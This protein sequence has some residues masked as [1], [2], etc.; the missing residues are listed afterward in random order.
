[1]GIF[2]KGT[3]ER[4]LR[5][6][7]L[8]L[9]K[10]INVCR[11]SETS[12]NLSKEMQEVVQLN[13]VKKIDRKPSK[14]ADSGSGNS[15]SSGNRESCSKGKLG[16]DE[17]SG[18]KRRVHHVEE[19]EQT[20]SEGEEFYVSS[21]GRHVGAVH[22]GSNR[23]WTEELQVNERKIKFKL[24]TGAESKQTLN[25]FLKINL[26]LR[27]WALSSVKALHVV[28]YGDKG[29]PR[30]T[31]KNLRNF[32]NFPWDKESEEYSTKTDDVKNKLSMPDLVAVC[33]VLDLNYAGSEDEVIERISSFLNDFNFEDENDDEDKDAR[34]DDG[35]KTFITRK[36]VIDDY[37]A[38]SVKTETHKKTWKNEEVRRDER[39]APQSRNKKEEKC[40]N[41]GIQGHRSTDCP[42]K[43]KGV[44]CFRCHQFGH[45]SSRCNDKEEELSTSGHVNIINLGYKNSV[46]L[47]V[48]QL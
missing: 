30:Q 24:D 29:L 12:K 43:A 46:T 15:N 21:L 10:T 13:V 39:R 37:D 26:N 17:A 18:S 19:H 36:T 47:K 20:D 22:E 1:I 5:E 38:K 32:T 9:Q 4:L 42:D 41:C 45:I 23:M 44:K 25:D 2:E 3:Q 31:R 35:D 8:T 7:S 6:T 28:A 33:N 14:Q 27:N 11:A 48:G 34:D 16:S 40:S